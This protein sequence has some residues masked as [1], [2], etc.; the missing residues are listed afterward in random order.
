MTEA[1]TVAV[2]AE[3]HGKFLSHVTK[4]ASAQAISLV[5]GLITAPIF[6]RLFAPEQVGTFTLFFSVITLVSTFGTMHY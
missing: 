2:S 3:K 4:L 6:G 5:L 1:V